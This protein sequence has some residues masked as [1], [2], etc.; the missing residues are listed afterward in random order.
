[1]KAKPIILDADA[2]RDILAGNVLTVPFVIKSIDPTW[3]FDSL[4][5]DPSMTK[6]DV[7]GMEYPKKVSGLWATFEGDCNP[8]FP[9]TKAP[10]QP[11]DILYVREPWYKDVNRY[12]YKGSYSK[13]EVFY[14][15]GKE[16]NLLWESPISLPAEAVRLYLKVIDVQVLKLQT[17]CQEAT[18][19]RESWDKTHTTPKPTQKSGRIT[20]YTSFPLDDIQETREYKGVPWYVKGNPWVWVVTCERS[21]PCTK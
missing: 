15:N 13:S 10:H 1:M 12:L 2:V 19:Y 7:D 21:K 17:F 9:M 11:Q 8:S 3:S 6:V 14:R 4:S 16:V 18:R 5:F 20:Q